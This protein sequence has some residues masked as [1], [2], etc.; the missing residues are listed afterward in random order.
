MERLADWKGRIS[1]ESNFV[2]QP[3]RHARFKQ[4]RGCCLLPGA[5]VEHRIENDAVLGELRLD[6][7]EK[8]RK[9]LRLRGQAVGRV[10]DGLIEGQLVAD[11]GRL[12]RGAASD[13]DSDGQQR[14][15]RASP[16]RAGLAKSR[17]SSALPLQIVR[18]FGGQRL[19]RCL[20]QNIT[21]PRTARVA[22]CA[23]PSARSATVSTC[24][25]RDRG[26]AV[27]AAGRRRRC[28][29]GVWRC[30]AGLRLDGCRCCRCSRRRGRVPVC[31]GAALLAAGRSMATGKATLDGAGIGI[32]AEA[33]AGTGGVQRQRRRRRRSGG[34]AEPSPMPHRWQRCERVARALLQRPEHG[35]A[36]AQ[37]NDDPG[38]DDERHAARARRR[39]DAATASR[40]RRA[41]TS[42][43]PPTQRRQRG[44]IGKAGSAALLALLSAGTDSAGARAS[45]CVASTGVRVPGTV[46]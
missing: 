42:P 43:E 6:L 10:G 15:R 36:N 20:L 44:C 30:D 26:A 4:D 46:L 32:A 24:A 23:R 21:A 8:S 28:D 29:G 1:N 40:S 17:R 35:A 38:D 5:G 39:V 16:C 11:Q 25:G 14:R 41:G 33:G 27:R 3:R 19:E 9:L 7:G 37:G 2:L 22:R 12:R 31:E 13:D 18:F 45:S 34:A